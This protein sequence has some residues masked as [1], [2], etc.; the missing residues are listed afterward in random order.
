MF[1]IKT[2]SLTLDARVRSACVRK[3]LRD[4]KASPVSTHGRWAD[5]RTDGRAS[6]YSASV[7]PPSLAGMPACL[8][9]CLSRLLRTVV[10]RVVVQP[11]NASVERERE[12]GRKKDD[13]GRKGA[14]VEFV[15]VVVMMMTMM[16]R[17]HHNG[18]FILR[19]LCF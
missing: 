12:G 6:A 19:A 1:P 17:G 14:S 3:L 10:G 2:N 5:G 8:P 16:M 13:G 18:K 4:S 9:A 11:E 15:V 7:R